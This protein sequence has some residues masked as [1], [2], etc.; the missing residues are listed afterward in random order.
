MTVKSTF[1]TETTEGWQFVLTASRAAFSVPFSP[2]RGFGLDFATTAMMLKDNSVWCWVENSCKFL[3]ERRRICIAKPVL[4]SC[5]C[6]I[7]ATGNFFSF[8]RCV[9]VSSFFFFLLYPGFCLILVG[10]FGVFLEG[11]VYHANLLVKAEFW[12]PVTVCTKI[13]FGNVCLLLS[14]VSLSAS[15]DGCMIPALWC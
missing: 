10:F 6:S 15:A 13:L 5:C 3:Q 12:L 8:N 14:L 11:R 2:H 9:E 4:A 7:Y 1:T